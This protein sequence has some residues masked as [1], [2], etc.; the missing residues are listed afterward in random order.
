MT[1]GEVVKVGV[2]ASGAAAGTGRVVGSG[3]K[4]RRVN[5]LEGN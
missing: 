2:V 5:K 3:L 1:A 4:I